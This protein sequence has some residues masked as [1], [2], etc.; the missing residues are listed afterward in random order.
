MDFGHYGAGILEDGLTVLS[1][2]F[3]VSAANCERWAA[4]LEGRGSHSSRHPAARRRDVAGLRRRRR[5]R[6]DDGERATSPGRPRSSDPTLRRRPL[7]RRHCTIHWP[8]TET[9]GRRSL[10]N[11][12]GLP[13][14]PA[15]KV[16]VEPTTWAADCSLFP[17]WEVHWWRERSEI[18][19]PASRWSDGQVSAARLHVIAVCSATYRG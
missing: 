1:T 17:G 2:V 7:P 5:R 8:T 13:S 19:F 10:L 12:T 11:P 14:E 4:V 3:A 18:V 15:D 6:R 9:A 16:D